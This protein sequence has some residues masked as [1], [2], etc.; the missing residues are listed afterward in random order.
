MTWYD[1]AELKAEAVAA[2]RQPE[3]VPDEELDESV[4]EAT[5]ALALIAKHQAFTTEAR[6]KL[7]IEE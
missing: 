1:P 2:E 6:E 3:F 4:E 5:K 7:G